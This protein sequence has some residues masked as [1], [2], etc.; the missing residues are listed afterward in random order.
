MYSTDTTIF[1]AFSVNTPAPCKILIFQT[2][3][4]RK[5]GFVHYFLAAC[6]HLLEDTITRQPFFEQGF[7]SILASGSMLGLVCLGI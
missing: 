2:Q 5:S 1:F 7:Q 3:D 4:E 6:S